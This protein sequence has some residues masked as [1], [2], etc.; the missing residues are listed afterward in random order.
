MPILFQ[1]LRLPISD[2]LSNIEYSVTCP[3]VKPKNSNRSP[4][5]A[6]RQSKPDVSEYR[7][8]LSESLGKRLCI[9]DNSRWDSLDDQVDSGSLGPYSESPLTSPSHSKSSSCDTLDS[10]DSG[11]ESSS[12][13]TG[14]HDSLDWSQ[15]YL[16]KSHY[17]Q[18]VH[19]SY[20]LD[21][22][23]S[24][25]AQDC[26]SDAPLSPLGSPT[27]ETDDEN[28]P[29]L[30]AFRKTGT[31]LEVR[32]LWVL[33]S[34]VYFLAHSGIKDRSFSVLHINIKGLVVRKIETC[35]ICD[36]F[37]LF[38]GIIHVAVYG[39]LSWQKLQNT[40]FFYCDILS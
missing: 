37:T 17:S 35:Y 4:L 10:L 20:N 25:L 1:K 19:F 32:N 13:M 39:S 27:L 2:P 12:H 6:Q 33:G 34:A 28:S 21:Q 15:N 30:I 14:S 38:L 26:S 9:A 5:S 3:H 23:T 40:T 11:L 22:R 18:A 36:K 31:V 24:E 8:S 7:A 16:S 29:T